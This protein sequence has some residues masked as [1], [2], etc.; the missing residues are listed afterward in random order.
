MTELIEI[1]TDNIDRRKLQKVVDALRAG[2]TVIYPTDTVYTLGCALSS[3][4]GLEAV[5]RLKEVKL[6]KARFS[7]VCSDLSHISDYSLPVANPVF[8][9]M[10]RLL[11]GSFTFIL[12]ANRNVPRI[13]AANRKTIGI[14]VPNHP[15]C[16]ELV[17]LLG[18]PLIS[19]SVHDE[20]EILEY[21]VYATDIY[22]K[23]SDKVDIIIDSGPCGLQP[24]TVLDCS[25]GVPEIIRKGKGLELISEL[26]D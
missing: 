24:S 9:L 12:E 16:L 4:K 17:K 25:T 18:E 26:E 11:P 13:F 2:A 1:F 3:P 23:W 10:K 22:E 19:T 8:K 15:V 7:I 21:S 6:E 5:A 20:D 14:R